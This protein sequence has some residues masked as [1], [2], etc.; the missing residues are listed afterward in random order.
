MPTSNPQRKNHKKTLLAITVYL[1]TLAI[2]GI[3]ML[4]ELW[5]IWAALA[6]AG[7]IVFVSWYSKINPHK[8][9]TRMV[10]LNI[11]LDV[12]AI[13]VWAAFPATQWSIYQLNF[14]IVGTEAA[15]AAGL[16]ALTVFG[17]TKKQKWAPFLAITIT[18]TQ[19]SFA[20]YVFFPS[21]AIAVTLIWS[22]LIIYF[23]YKEIKS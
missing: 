21:T 13:V 12:F 8:I 5:F 16:F 1:A 15:V 3:F 22:L 18:A 17:L 20:T 4:F 19:R 9:L 14:P 6:V 23:A 10:A 7:V 2:T 11:G